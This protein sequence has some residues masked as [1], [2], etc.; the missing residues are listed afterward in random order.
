MRKSNINFQVQYQSHINNE[1]NNNSN[2]I[3]NNNININN[4]YNNS[5][6]RRKER[7]N[8]KHDGK[9]YRKESIRDEMRRAESLI[10]RRI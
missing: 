2:F 3:N 7:G 6:H 1:K 4:N 5:S 9:E 10:H 8:I